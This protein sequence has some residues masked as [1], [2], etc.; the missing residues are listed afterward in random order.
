MD[1]EPLLSLDES[2]ATLGAAQ[3]LERRSTGGKGNEGN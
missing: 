1:V 3:H 2:G